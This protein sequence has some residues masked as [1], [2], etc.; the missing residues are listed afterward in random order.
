MVQKFDL[1]NC[2]FNLYGINFLDQ[3]FGPFDG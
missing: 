3:I 1:K 2:S